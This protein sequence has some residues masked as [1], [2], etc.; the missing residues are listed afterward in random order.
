MKTSSWSDNKVK[1]SLWDHQIYNSIDDVCVSE[2]ESQIFH[3]VIHESGS[4]ENPAH[5][6]KRIICCNGSSHGI[7]SMISFHFAPERTAS[8]ENEPSHMFVISIRSSVQS[9]KTS[10]IIRLY[11]HAVQKKKKM[12]IKSQHIKLVID[13][14]KN[15]D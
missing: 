14:G 9:R 4:E 7:I 2:R 15:K 8:H 10:L 6:S 5:A 3:T 1:V 11:D 12:K 13:C